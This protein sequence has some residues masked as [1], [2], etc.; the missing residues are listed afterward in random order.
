[1]SVT[2]VNAIEGIAFTKQMPMRSAS[3]Q[4]GLLSRKVVTSINM[5]ST[6]KPI[7]YRQTHNKELDL[8]IHTTRM[9]QDRVRGGVGQKGCA[10]P[11]MAIKMNG[12]TISKALN[13][14]L[15]IT[16]LLIHR[17]DSS[18]VITPNH[19]QQPYAVNVERNTLPTPD[20]PTL[21]REYS[22]NRYHFNFGLLCFAWCSFSKKY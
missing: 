11:P 8:S 5:S 4:L 18:L 15:V 9:Q 7:Q 19:V 12:K 16:L 3:R 17:S 21:M 22:Q 2:V 10:L 13:G 14:K 1:M 6:T 20:R